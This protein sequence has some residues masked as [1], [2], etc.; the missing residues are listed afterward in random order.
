MTK[1]IKLQPMYR[2]HKHNRTQIVPKLTMSGKWLAQ[3]G[4]HPSKLIHVEVQNN[5]L[6][7]TS[8]E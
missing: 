1:I 7:I 2:E 6:I 4:F 8:I 3:A 5:R